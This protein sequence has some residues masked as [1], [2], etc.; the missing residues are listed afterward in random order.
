MEFANIEKEIIKLLGLKIKTQIL[1]DWITELQAKPEVDMYNLS[2]VSKAIIE[3]IARKEVDLAEI[4]E[5]EIFE[6][7]LINQEFKV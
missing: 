2:S 6:M 7:S 5:S 1:N 4:A 3:F